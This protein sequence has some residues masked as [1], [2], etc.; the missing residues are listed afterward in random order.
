[1]SIDNARY[2]LAD[3]DLSGMKRKSHDHDDRN[4]IMSVY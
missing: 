3:T 4:D 2:T 1:M